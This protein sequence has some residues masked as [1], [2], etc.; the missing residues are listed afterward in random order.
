[1]GSNVAEVPL[2]RSPAARIATGALNEIIAPV[3]RDYDFV[4]TELNFVF[5]SNIATAHDVGTYVASNKGKGLRQ[6]IVLLSAACVGKITP[7]VR[8]GAAGVELLQTSTLLHDDVID[9]SPLRRGKPSV[10]ARWGNEIAVLMG[11]AI[12]TQALRMFVLTDSLAVMD[13]SAQQARELIEGE[14]YARDLRANPDFSEASYVDLIRRKTGALM[15]L[16]AIVGSMLG[17]GDDDETASMREYGYHLGMAFQIA[18]DLL[19]VMGNPKIV[20]KPTGQDIRDGTVTLPLIRALAAASEREAAAMR[21][22][23]RAGVRTDAEWLRV[24]EFI[25]AHN[26]IRSALDTAH[27]YSH[28]AQKALAPFA[29]SPARRS[30]IKLLDYVINRQL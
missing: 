26:G 23:I 14:I 17:N 29:D 7:E 30:M 15:A 18:D 8:Y 4:N 13:I 22:F 5:T 20:G 11:D 2:Q 10:N 27:A 6:A 19:D 1:M 9:D 28:V 24:R 25:E 3:R 12:L 21:E 16:A